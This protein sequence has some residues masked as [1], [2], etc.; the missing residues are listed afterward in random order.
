M[1]RPF[2]CYTPLTVSCFNMALVGYIIN[3]SIWGG[4]VMVTFTI[5]GA[6][7]IIIG[8]IILIE[9][10]SY[11]EPERKQILQKIKESPTYIILI[12]LMP[13]GIVINVIGGFFGADLIVIT[14]ASLIILQGLIVAI[15]FWKWKRWKSIFLFV[16]ILI[17]GI[18]MYVPL[19]I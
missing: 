12:A 14:G 10:D 15:L 9:F 1:I 7:I 11:P 5:T 16:V 4:F 13:I 6:M 19:L 18:A 3:E 8:W 2:Y 17:L